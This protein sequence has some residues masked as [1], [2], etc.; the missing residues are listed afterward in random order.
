MPIEDALQGATPDAIPDRAREPGV[1]R[2]DDG[3][4]GAKRSPRRDDAER[5]T[6]AAVH[7]HDVEP[8]GAEQRGEPRGQPP[9]DRESRD[10]AVGVNHDAG[11][12]APHVCR[13]GSLVPHV[14]RHDGRV[15]AE[16]VE[17]AREVMH[18]LRHTTELG[19]VIFRDQADAERAHRVRFASCSTAETTAVGR[20]S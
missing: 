15:V 10:A 20:S 4:T 9:A 8:L 13:I 2:G 5:R 1:E 6:Q 17:L 16:A 14:R 3:N 19:V 12:D 7:V 18:V 11:A